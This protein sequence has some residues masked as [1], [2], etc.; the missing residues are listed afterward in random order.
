VAPQ[1]SRELVGVAEGE[2]RRD[3]DLGAVVEGGDDVHAALSAGGAEKLR[4]AVGNPL[5]KRPFSANATR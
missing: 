4:A 5:A 3:V 2:E 1:H